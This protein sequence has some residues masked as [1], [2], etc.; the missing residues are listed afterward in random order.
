[1]GIPTVSRTFPF[2]AAHRLLDYPGKCRHIHGHSYKATVKVETCPGTAA[3]RA[4][5]PRFLGRDTRID[6]LGM[7][8]DFGL[9]KKV[10]GGWIDTHWDHNVILNPDDPLLTVRRMGPITMIPD[11]FLGKEPYIMPAQWPNP[12]AENMAMALMRDVG[13]L[14]RKEGLSLVKVR[15]RETEACSAAYELPR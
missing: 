2:E 15:I 4:T 8:A 13:D 9:L 14:L 1:M 3:S 5:D 7:V 11:V 6:N 10:V 12:T